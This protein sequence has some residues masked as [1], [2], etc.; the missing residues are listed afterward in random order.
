MNIIQEKIRLIKKYRELKKVILKLHED[1]ENRT[2]KGHPYLKK[3]REEMGYHVDTYRIA[4]AWM[5]LN[6]LGK[7]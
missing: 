7:I 5:I 6:L 1:P 3:I 4:Q 2:S